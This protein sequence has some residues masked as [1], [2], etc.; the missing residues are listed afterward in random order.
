MTKSNDDAFEAA[1]DSSGEDED[2]GYGRPPRST[3]FQPGVSGNPSG[4]P[5]G[6]KNRSP[7]KS[8]LRRFRAVVLEEA[9]RDVTVQEHDGFFQVPAMTAAMRSVAEQAASGDQNAQHLLFRL[10]AE[11]EREERAEEQAAFRAAIAYKEKASETLA[12]RKESGQF[13]PPILPDPE[14]V[15]INVFAQSVVIRGP[16]TVEEQVEWDALQAD[17]AEAER[18]VTAA[19]GRLRLDPHGPA[20]CLE[21]EVAQKEIE[22]IDAELAQFERIVTGGSG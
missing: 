4:R 11:V 9:Y 2:V 22:R 20:L 1:P 10:V 14:H 7:S 13:G 21:L 5:K 8:A 12:R 19:E 6:S 15:H 3:R 18:R 16:E 17:R